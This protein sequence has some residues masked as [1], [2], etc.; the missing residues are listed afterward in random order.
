MQAFQTCLEG[1]ESGETVSVV[2][3]RKGIEEY[4]EIEYQVVIGAR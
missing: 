4:K 3:Q 2:I 1:L